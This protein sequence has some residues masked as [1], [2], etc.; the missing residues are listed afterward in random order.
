MGCFFRIIWKKE[1]E[2][3]N[4]DLSV[5]LRIMCKCKE[6]RFACRVMDE[7]LHPTTEKM[8]L[9]Y[10]KTKRKGIRLKNY[11]RT[12]LLY[13]SVCLAEYD[14]LGLRSDKKQN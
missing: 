1:L 4:Q 3:K 14:P 12:E 5:C 10:P 6:I 13:V 8:A 7:Y 11:K 9:L 2:S